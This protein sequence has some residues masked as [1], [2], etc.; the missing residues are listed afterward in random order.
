MSRNPFIKTSDNSQGASS[1][2]GKHP[3]PFDASN[4]PSNDQ[5]PAFPAT[6]TSDTKPANPFTAGK[7]NG[8]TPK[9]LF[10]NNR[11]QEENKTGEASK[12]PFGINKDKKEEKKETSALDKKEENQEETKKEAKDIFATNKQIKNASNPFGNKDDKK[13]STNMFAKKDES[14]KDKEKENAKDKDKL[15]TDPKIA[16]SS[17]GE[18]SKSEINN[19]TIDKISQEWNTQLDY[20]SEKFKTSAD[21]LREQELEFFR[22]AEVINQLEQKSDEILSQSEE[23][24]RSIKEIENRQADLLQEL[25]KFDSNLSENLFPSNTDPSN[26][27][28]TIS[29]IFSKTNTELSHLE[30]ALHDIHLM[31]NINSTHGSSNKPS[32]LNSIENTVTQQYSILSWMETLLDD[33]SVQ[34]QEFE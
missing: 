21:K 2:I 16:S 20:M 24:E 12:N 14:S 23:K 19:K 33:L 1:M 29:E 25:Q 32:F 11:K 10:E 8:S 13:T 30:S 6:R 28:Q 18:A 26:P 15:K 22:V 9:N 3:N 7:K 5:R 27:R 31:S 17:L 4:K 34:V